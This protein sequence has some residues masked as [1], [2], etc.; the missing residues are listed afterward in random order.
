M[1]LTITI[2]N[3]QVQR[4]YNSFVIRF[5]QPLADE[6]QI[7]FAKKHII[8]LIKEIVRRTEDQTAINLARVSAENV[9]EPD[10]T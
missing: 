1:N 5:G 9:A 3:D 10:I 8:K 2:P 6:T 7:Q 4:I